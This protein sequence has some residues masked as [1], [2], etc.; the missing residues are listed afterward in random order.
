MKECGG[1]NG[2]VGWTCSTDSQVGEGKERPSRKWKLEHL[3][4]ERAR[5][6]LIILAAPVHVVEGPH[7]EGEECSMNVRT[8]D[9]LRSRRL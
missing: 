6:V 5:R 1:E 4:D 9:R 2:T 8:G 3:A 7:A